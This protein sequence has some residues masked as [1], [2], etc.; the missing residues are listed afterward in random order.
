MST[1]LLP[2]ELY[3]ILLVLAWSIIAGGFLWLINRMVKNFDALKGAVTTG[4]NAIIVTINNHNT[5]HSERFGKQEARLQMV[6]R[7]C[8]DIPKLWLMAHDLK[9]RTQKL[10]GQVENIVYTKV[11]K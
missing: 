4:F 10:E 9:E 3:N 2:P 7:D 11:T 5:A 6:E 8:Q 1:Q